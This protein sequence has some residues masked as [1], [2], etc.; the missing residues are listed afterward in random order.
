[1]NDSLIAAID[2]TWPFV[3]Q[4]L[5]ELKPESVASIL[6]CN[7]LTSDLSRNSSDILAFIRGVSEERAAI[8]LKN[9][10]VAG[11]IKKK[12]W[13]NSL[14]TFKAAKDPNLARDNFLKLLRNN[15]IN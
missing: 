13:I 8:Y 10:G 5:H 9:Q 15:I 12:G 1:M 4:L 3:E 2:S 6:Y 11:A 14:K 7:S